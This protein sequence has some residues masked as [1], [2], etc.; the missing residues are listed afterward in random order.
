MGGAADERYLPRQLVAFAARDHGLALERGPEVIEPEVDG[1]DR[2]EMAERHPHRSPAAGV[3]QADDRARRKDALVR[4]AD[5]LLAP[6][7]GQFDPVVAGLAIFE[8]QRPAMADAA[9]QL[10]EALRIEAG[11][12]GHAAASRAAVSRT[13]AIMLGT[14][15]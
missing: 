7:Q 11:G 13:S 8:A 4:D 6:R 1:H 2:L 10:E 14:P 3:E 9:R 12:L 5:Q 15:C